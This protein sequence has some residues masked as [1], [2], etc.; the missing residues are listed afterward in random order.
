MEIELND[1]TFK[2]DKDDA[3]NALEHVSFKAGPGIHLLLGEN[4]AG[5]TTLLH[6]IAGLLRPQQGRCTIDGADTSLRLP[7]INSKLFMA[8][9]NLNFPARNILEF[10]RIHSPFY[11]NY[12]AG[13]LNNNLI[14][15]NMT[16]RESFRSLSDG[17]IMKLKVAYALA[18]H[19]PILLL[20]EPTNCL[21]IDSKR[22]L[23]QM[24][25]ENITP[26]Q[27]VIISTHSVTDLE[28]FYDGVIDIS[29]GKLNYCLDI[30]EIIRR[31]RFTITDREP[32][33]EDLIYSEQRIGHYHNIEYNR[34]GELTNPDYELLYMAVRN[35]NKPILK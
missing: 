18:L 4:G 16:G 5:K 10:A 14:R 30:D 17:N 13:L 1:V 2:Y 24:I 33:E 11:P 23:Q 19:T 12:D 34:T 25:A 20:D 27:T 3:D 21:D 32:A 7:S 31:V 22:A 9:I 6:V 15:L 35:S 29:N 8:G 28:N 26:E